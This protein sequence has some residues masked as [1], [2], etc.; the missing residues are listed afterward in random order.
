MTLAGLGWLVAA[1]LVALWQLA[2]T[3]RH[4][5]EQRTAEALKLAR[6][7]QEDSRALV[8]ILAKVEETFGPIEEPMLTRKD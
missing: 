5:A 1:A 2:E 8:D 4:A 6:E 7:A 3:K